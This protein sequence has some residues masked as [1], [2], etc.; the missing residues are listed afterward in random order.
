MEFVSLFT[1]LGSDRVSAFYCQHLTREFVWHP[2]TLKHPNG[3]TGLPEV[4]VADPGAEAWAI[5]AFMAELD[6]TP[7][8]TLGPTTIRTGSTG[9]GFRADRQAS[10]ALGH[11][12]VTLARA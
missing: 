12:S 8:L 9:L 10:A 6:P 4:T 2:A 5:L 7:Q 3:A 11:V 1:D